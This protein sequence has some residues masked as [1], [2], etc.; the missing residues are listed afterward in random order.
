[1]LCIASVTN[2]QV[3]FFVEAPSANEGGYEISVPAPGADWGVP[4]MLD[5][6]NVITGTMCRAMDP[7][8]CDVLTN[9]PDL[10]GKIAVV[11]RGS[12]EFG[13]KALQAQ[14]EGA[15]A[16]IIVNHSPGVIPMGG[17]AEGINVTIPVIMVSNSTGAVLADEIDACNSTAIIGNLNGFFENNLRITKAGILRSSAA[18][19]V[20]A[21][22]TDDNE[23]DIPTGAWVFNFGQVN[24]AAAVLNVEISL[25]GTTVF[26]ESSDELSIAVGDSMF[27]EMPTFSQSLSPANF[28]LGDVFSYARLNED[29]QANPTN[30]TSP[31]EVAGEQN[32]C[33][34]FE[35]PNASRIVVNSMSITGTHF[36][37]TIA[38]MDIEIVAYEWLDEDMGLETTFGVFNELESQG[39][40]FEAEQDDAL[41]VIDFDAPVEVEDDVRY[42]FCIRHLNDGLQLGYD[43]STDYTETVF[44]NQRPIFPFFDE[45]ESFPLLF[46]EDLAPAVSLNT[47]TVS[48]INDISNDVDVTPFPNPANEILNI[49]FNNNLR[50][51]AVINIFNL[52]GQL[53]SSQRVNV[54]ASRLAVDVSNIANGSYVFNVQFENQKQSTFNVV[55]NR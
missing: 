48:G 45:A 26:N 10:V 46:G 37:T 47:S 49:P 43:N 41:I 39:Y 4:D 13:F 28:E 3:S 18:G 53:V 11:T 21:L 55:V 22:N 33:I 14:N 19:Q 16:V 27:V 7:E 30:Y 31:A 9:G 24:E 29:N 38:D 40:T 15:I 32:Y 34:L 42:A 52:E 54:N 23:F 1:M 36:E 8:A 25:D 2:A 12:C 35:D 50:G 6:A 5:P 20:A 17:G 51:D 44:L